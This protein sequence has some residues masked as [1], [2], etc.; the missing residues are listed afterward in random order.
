MLC[1]VW[2]YQAGDRLQDEEDRCY[3]ES[4]DHSWQSGNGSRQVSDVGHD[5]R[6]PILSLVPEKGLPKSRHD[7]LLP[8]II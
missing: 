1:E 2:N 7:D 4:G 6:E 8:E 5:T 3:D